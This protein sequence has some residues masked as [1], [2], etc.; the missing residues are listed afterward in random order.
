[1]IRERR[2][3][4]KKL[5]A[6]SLTELLV[7]LVIIGVLVLLALPNFMGL[8]GDAN[9]AEAKIGLG[10]IETL[11]KNYFYEHSKYAD[12][13]DAIGYEANKLITEGGNSK[14]LFEVVEAST[15]GFTAKAT[16][17]VDFDGDGTMNVWQINQEKKLEEVI[18]D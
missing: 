2:I 9:S 5:K 11:Q 16:A 14:Y 6:F 15:T 17:V 12:N 10:H 13:L 3:A 18:G 8:I 4:N 1:M 7:V